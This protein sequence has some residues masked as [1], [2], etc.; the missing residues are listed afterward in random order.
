MESLLA[1]LA[2]GFSA[3]VTPGPLLALVVASTLA[4]GW[5]GGVQA[6]IAPLISDLPIIVLCITV[7]SVVPPTF[8]GWLSIAG[9]AVLIWFAVETLNEARSATIA[10]TPA[11]PTPDRTW[12][13]A[14]LVNALSPSPWLFWATIGGPILVAT[15]RDSPPSATAFIV[16]FYLLLI[17]TKVAVAVGLGATRHRLS[18]R[19]YRTILGASGVLMVVLAI[20]LAAN[21]Y[22]TLTT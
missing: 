2:L 3:G 17:G 19:A 7:V 6:A 12:V 18:T 11:E 15:W 8:V 10:V 1:G 22:Q 16:G 21:G 5:R 9:A 20:A 14:A 13:K 4:R